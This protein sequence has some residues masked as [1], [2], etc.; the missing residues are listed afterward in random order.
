MFADSHSAPPPSP[1]E[2]LAETEHALQT[3][4]AQQE[5]LASGI[6]HDLRAPL[7]AISSYAA[8]IDQHHAAGLGDEGR[9]HLRRIREA[10]ARMDGLIDGLLQLSHVTR[11][12]LRR[13]PV[14]V[15][16]LVE[17]CL[18]ELQDAEPGRKLEATVQ[19]ELSA[20]G[21]ERQLKQLFER[22]LQNAW[23]FSAPGAARIRI[24]GGPVDG[25]MRIEVRDEGSGFDMRYAGRLF[26]P[27]QR[28][29]PTDHG[30][31]NGLGLAIAQAIV[32]RHGGRIAADSEPGRGSVFRVE[33]PL[34][35]GAEPTGPEIAA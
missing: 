23:K 29:H 21:D 22:L 9:D 18:A 15:S 12:P 35:P 19:P 30:G 2:R 13:E 20:H 27:F 16:L 34:A 25:Y 4:R 3:L 6:S 26:E 11:A 24:S 28:L 5:V 7:R 31:G 33:L 10:A 1:E 32:E 8:L 17:W 14:D